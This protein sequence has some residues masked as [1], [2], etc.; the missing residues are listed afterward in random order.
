MVII[1]LILLQKQFL[2][3]FEYRRFQIQDR[4]IVAITESVV[5]RAQG[6]YADIDA[7]AKDISSKFQDDTIGVIF[8]ILSRNAVLPYA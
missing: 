4:D 1:L 2:K 3:G 7:I 8:P 5:A 6:N